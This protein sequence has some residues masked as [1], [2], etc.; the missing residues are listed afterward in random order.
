M[1]RLLTRTGTGVA[2]ITIVVVQAQL[3]IAQIPVPVHHIAIRPDSFSIILSIHR[4]T[5]ASCSVFSPPSGALCRIFMRSMIE[6]VSYSD[7][8]LSKY[9]TNFTI[10]IFSIQKSPTT[11]AGLFISDTQV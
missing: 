10:T 6:A 7:K 5:V 2:I 11:S 9:M 4:E 3:P 1:K 8:L